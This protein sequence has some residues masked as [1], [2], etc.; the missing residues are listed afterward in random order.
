MRATTSERI[1][2]SFGCMFVV[3]VCSM[4]GT[5]PMRLGMPFDAK[6]SSFLSKGRCETRKVVAIG[7]KKLL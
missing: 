4:T 5:T 7:R 2:S 6:R 1:D 3:S